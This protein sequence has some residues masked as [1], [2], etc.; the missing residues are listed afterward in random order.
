MESAAAVRS[1][2][3]P[4]NASVPGLPED[5]EDDPETAGTIVAPDAV[6]PGTE[7]TDLSWASGGAGP[8]GAGTAGNRPGDGEPET[9]QPAGAEAGMPPPDPVL[10]PDILSD[11]AGD[12]S[13]EA[14]TEGEP[15]PG[16]EKSQ[17]GEGV[18]AEAGADGAAPAAGE[19]VV[20]TFFIFRIR[21][22]S[23]GPRRGSPRHA[24]E[25]GQGHDHGPGREHRP[26]RGGGKPGEAQPAAAGDAGG[27]P[28]RREGGGKRPDR[29]E[30]EAGRH[31]AKGK[32]PKR[33]RQDKGEPRQFEAKPPRR[34][35][36]VDPDSPFAI[37]QQLKNR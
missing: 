30:G 22:R 14:A 23:R 8:A 19:A 33:D 28:E 9:A 21:P 25:Q 17:R 1:P 15:A 34:D 7:A 36:P 31:R 12:N 32:G 16:G 24:G 5:A 2:D 11:A 35:K 26:R 6:L 29:P 27:R 13:G 3:G 4:D 20:E 10:E 18:S 37:L